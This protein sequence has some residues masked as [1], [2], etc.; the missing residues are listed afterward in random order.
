M[1]VNNIMQEFDK[2]IKAGKAGIVC[3]AKITNYDAATKTVTVQN[4]MGGKMPWKF[5]NIDGG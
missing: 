4:E 5:E 3:K 1:I 2:Q